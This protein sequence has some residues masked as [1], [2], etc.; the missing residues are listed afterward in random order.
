[1]PGSKFSD[2]FS[3]YSGRTTSGENSLEID[4]A[5]S[6]DTMRFSRNWSQKE[7]AKKLGTSQSA[8]SRLES[9]WST[10][11]IAFLKKVATVFD[12]TLRVSFHEKPQIPR[13]GF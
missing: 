4:I 1:M 12:K 8:I 10:P 2:P 13:E 11:S 9:G 7:L 3:G 5:I 6:I